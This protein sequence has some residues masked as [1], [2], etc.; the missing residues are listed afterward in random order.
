M[1]KVLL[2]SALC[3]MVLCLTGCSAP[4]EPSQPDAQTAAI[5]TSLNQ[6]AQSATVSLA[7]LSAIQMAQNPGMDGLPFASVHDKA[8]SQLI[9]VKWYGP[10]EPLLQMVAVKAGYQLQVYGKAPSLP[11]LVNIDDT[12]SLVPALDVVRNAALQAGTKVTIEIYEKRHVIS[13]RYR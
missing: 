11:V 5:E 8:L 9:F 2:K 4:V 3:V 6:A 13:L 7:Q 10:I 12:N 1:N